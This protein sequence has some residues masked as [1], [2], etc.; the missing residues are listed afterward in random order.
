L[1]VSSPIAGCGSVEYREHLFS[2]LEVSIE[3]GVSLTLNAFGSWQPLPPD[4]GKIDVRG[5][6]Y[7]IDLRI[8]SVSEVTVESLRFIDISSGDTIAVGR[9]EQPL[10]RGSQQLFVDRSGIDLQAGDQR[11]EGV[12]VVG[13][14]E[15]TRSLRFSGVL[16]H[17]YR[18]ER[19]SQFLEALRGI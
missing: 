13:L 17:E 7:T 6:P 9:L 3:S 11:V 5:P 1:V 14:G 16:V 4:S 10:T 15:E 19:R 18:V 8:R 2:E 12:L